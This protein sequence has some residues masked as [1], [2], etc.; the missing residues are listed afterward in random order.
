MLYLTELLNRRGVAVLF[1]V[2]M[3]LMASVPIILGKSI[4]R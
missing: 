1:V 3:D 4:I 2:Q